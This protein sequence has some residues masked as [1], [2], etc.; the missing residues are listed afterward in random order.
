MKTRAGD[1]SAKP[2]TPMISSKSPEPKRKSMGQIL[3]HNPQKKTNPADTSVSNFQSLE[4][5][6]STFLLS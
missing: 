4:L 3:F 2:G 6:N 1:A 5:R